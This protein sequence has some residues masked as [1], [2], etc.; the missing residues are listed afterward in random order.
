MTVA[1]I[2]RLLLAG[3]SRRLRK[4]SQ[5]KVPIDTIIITATNAAIGICDTH[6]SR[7]TTRI[8]SMTPATSVDRR[9]RPPD[10]TLITD[11][12]IIA[13]PAMPPRKR[14]EEHTSELQSRENLVCRLLLEIK[15]Y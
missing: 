15:N 6:S 7:N 1:S 12:P 3:C 14:S 2:T 5:L 10:F 4:D 13:Q 8:S 11:W 9:P